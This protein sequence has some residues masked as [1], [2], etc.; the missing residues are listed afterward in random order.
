MKF[1]RIKISS[2]TA[3]F[4]Y[5]NIISGYQPTLEVPPVSTILG[6]LN[7][8][9][10]KYIRHG[11][12]NLGYYFDFGAKEVD[13]ETIYQLEGDS[14]GIPKNQAKSNVIKR[15]FLY[16]CRLF[17]YL[18]DAGLVEFFRN[19][20]YQLVLGRS[21]DLATV[22][23]I[24]GVEMSPVEN[25][26]KIKGQAIPFR[27]NFLPGQLQA[28]PKYFTDTFPRRNIGTEPYSIISHREGAGETGMNAF[29][30]TIDG[31]EVDIYLHNLSFED[32]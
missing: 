24:T 1:Y 25:A 7:A 26:C 4:R 14:K 13:L 23:E 19:P 10:G 27:G 12:L 21:A 8:C 18:E 31:V 2:W 29:R 20:V 5:P 11:T 32:E 16:D 15:E 3:S 28:L 22:E 9:A 17:I 30:D 6:L